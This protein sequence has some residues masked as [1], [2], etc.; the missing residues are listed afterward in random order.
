VTNGKPKVRRHV[1]EILKD[2]PGW[3]FVGFDGS[4]HAILKNPAFA[5]V[6]RVPC[7]PRS[8][9]DCIIVTRQRIKRVERGEAP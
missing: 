8:E 3:A 7:T 2:A 4:T 5:S 9:S 1:R 6:V